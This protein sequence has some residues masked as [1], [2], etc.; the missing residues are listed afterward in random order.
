MGGR[1]RGRGRGEGEG[2][3]ILSL[4]LGGELG[5]GKEDEGEKERWG[6]REETRGREKERGKPGINGD[7][8]CRSQ[9]LHRSRASMPELVSID[10][11]VNIRYWWSF[12]PQVSVELRNSDHDG[13][14]EGRDRERTSELGAE[15]FKDRTVLVKVRHLGTEPHIDTILLQYQYMVWYKTARRTEFW[16]GTRLRTDSVPI[17]YT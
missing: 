3:K 12:R 9:C 11:G 13:R 17:Q 5:V 10:H 7:R 2:D 8:G 4:I 15:V 1:E 6:E 16:Y 14:G